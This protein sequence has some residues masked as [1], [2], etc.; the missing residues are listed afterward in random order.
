MSLTTPETAAAATITVP[1]LFG[2]I[3]LLGIY[4]SPDE[5]RALV[6]MRSG[7]TQML[8]TSTPQ[9]DFTLIGIGDGWAVIQIAGEV[10]QLSVPG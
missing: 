3:T 6:R 1:D 10:R 4:V 2:E 8:S 7:R 5:S 9:G